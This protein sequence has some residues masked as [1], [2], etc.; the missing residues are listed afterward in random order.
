MRG[1]IIQH[2]SLQLLTRRRQPFL[3]SI[4][5]CN[6]FNSF[7]AKIKNNA[8]HDVT[9][10][11]IPQRYH[12]R[13]QQQPIILRSYSSTVIRK[14]SDRNDN[15][16]SWNVGF[17]AINGFWSHLTNE[18]VRDTFQVLVQQKSINQDILTETMSGRIQM[19]ALLHGL[20][21]PLLEKYQWDAL[22]FTNAVGPA[23]Q[24]Y[25]ETLLQLMTEAT[26]K[27]IHDNN[28]N[29]NKATGNDI[30]KKQLATEDEEDM[31]E[32]EDKNSWRKE[33][34][35]DSN[36]LVGRFLKIVT[37]DNFN[38][39]YRNAQMI[40]LFYQ[41]G[42]PTPMNYVQGSC[43]VEYLSLINV[44]AIEM[45]DA[46]YKHNEHPEFAASR[47]DD[48]VVHNLPVF[49]RIQVLYQLTRQF[50]ERNINQ[51]IQEQQQQSTSPISALESYKSINTDVS[52]SSAT[53]TPTTTDTTS[54]DNNNSDLTNMANATGKEKD[55]DTV[56]SP[57]DASNPIEDD[58][59]PTTRTTPK[60]Y[61][62]T[63]LGIAT[64]E[65]WLNGGSN[66]ADE[67]GNSSS[68]N[69]S[70]HQTQQLR[71]KVASAAEFYQF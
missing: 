71:W 44:K 57:T 34:I 23:L 15:V 22:E 37:K 17:S 25:H 62:E 63:R 5:Y 48:D 1:F 14:R 52:T 12:H 49:A 26:T 13:Q 45:D 33:A 41:M 55:T 19:F 53:T 65:G 47:E 30:N 11:V 28:K 67:D 50:Q 54:K 9:A 7:N 10:V 32:E 39:Q 61:T 68:I 21:N 56:N 16:I 36:S 40:Q 24:I 35:Q 60:T 2:H 6:N 27:T 8:V 66:S 29:N 58:I 4:G 38:E 51:S 18:T 42:M 69:N 70:N 20:M 64:F 43:R 59:E 31:E 46:L 3:R